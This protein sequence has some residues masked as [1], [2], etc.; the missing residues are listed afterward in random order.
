MEID[1]YQEVAAVNWNTHHQEPVMLDDL[2]LLDSYYK[3]F[4]YM[5]RK[6]ESSKYHLEHCLLPGQIIAFNNRRFLHSRNS[7]QLN[8]GFR[9]FHTTYVNIDYLRSQFLV[10]GKAL[11]FNESPKNIFMSTL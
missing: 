8:G 9:N 6:I 7:F 11:G 1:R 3:A 10:L 5:S 2:D 4:L